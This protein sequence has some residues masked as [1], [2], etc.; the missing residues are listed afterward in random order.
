MARL[1]GKTAIVTGGARGMGAA[2]CRLF[3]EEGARVVIADVLEAEGQALARELGDAARF[4]RLDVTEEADWAHV[5]AFATEVFGRIDVLVNNAAI[6]MFGGVTELT[7]QDFERVLSINLVGTF[8]GIRT[9]APLMKAQGSGSIVNISSVDGLRGVNALAPYVASKWGVRGLTKVAALELGHQGVRV[10][11]V[12]PGGVNTVMSNP[13]GAPLEEIN[14]HYANVPLQRVG[15]PE[16]VARAT[17]FLA[18][19]EG[20]YCNGAELAVDGG[21]T[22]GAYYPGLPGAPF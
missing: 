8:T 1:A 18:S 15:L 6:L 4:V 7:K 9:I 3:V 5:A 21:M 14:K 20:S 13:T 2:T 17:L 12:H 16:E 22:A 10:N 19:D 11:S